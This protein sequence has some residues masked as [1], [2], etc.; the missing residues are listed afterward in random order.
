MSG[1]GEWPF[2][3][4]DVKV[5]DITGTTQEDLPAA[6]TLRWRERLATGELT[7]DDVIKTVV[8]S[9]QAIDWELEGG[10]ISLDAWALL[11]GRTPS[12]SGTTPNRTYT[13]TASGGDVFPWV[14]IYGKS[15]GDSSDDVHVKLFK[16]K[17]TALEGTF[18]E[19]EFFVTRCEGVAVDDGT[20]GIADVVQNETA[21]DLPSS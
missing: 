14:K 11:T 21:T 12:E 2:G 8:S 13:M 6:R 4:R 3:L 20:N 10:G 15:V 9:L 17:V 16:A 18:G 1:Y 19:N 7:G 5:T